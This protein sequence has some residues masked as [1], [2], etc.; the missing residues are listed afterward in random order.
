MSGGDLH[1]HHAA[2]SRGVRFGLRDTSWRAEGGSYEER[3][4]QAYRLC[5]AYNLMEGIPTEALEAGCLRKFYDAAFD[6]RQAAR[7]GDA[8]RIALAVASLDAAWSAHQLDTREG[9]LN[10]CR[11]CNPGPRGEP[12]QGELLEGGCR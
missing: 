11:Q 12:V 9:R 6:L 10:D 2:P 5:L 7:S 8:A 3:R 1:R 4:A